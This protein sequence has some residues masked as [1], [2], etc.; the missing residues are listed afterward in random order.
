LVVNQLSHVPAIQNQNQLWTLVSAFILYP[1]MEAPPPPSLQDAEDDVPEAAR[2]MRFET[3]WDKLQAC[4]Q[5]P[6]YRQLFSCS[7]VFV[8]EDDMG[9]LRALPSEDRARKRKYVL[10][11]SF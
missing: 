2:W 10:F 6:Y 5:A 7:Y 3:S 11:F 9:R 4:L 8:Q 1:A